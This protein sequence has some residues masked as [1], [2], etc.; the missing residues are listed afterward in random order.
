MNEASIDTKT[1][2]LNAAEKLFGENGFDSTSLRD[3]TAEANV[4]LAAVNYHFQSKES[5]ADAVIERRIKPVNERRIA[6]LEA[7]GPNPTVE[8]IVEAFLAPILERD[9]LPAVPAIGRALCS[10]DQFVERIFKKHLM[11]IAQRFREALERALPS[12]SPEER[13]WRLNFMGGAMSHVL[14]F[15]EVLPLMTNGL[16]QPGDRRA[17]LDRMVIF[18]AAGFRAPETAL[19]SQSSEKN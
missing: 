8:Q 16:C 17:L 7:A 4:N 3:I 2:I 12:L 10:P 11:P 14:V 15:S 6:M 9:I 1:K 18:L 13:A 5:L 19:S